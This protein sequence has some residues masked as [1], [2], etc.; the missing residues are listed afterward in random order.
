MNYLKQENKKINPLI[1]VFIFFANAIKTKTSLV[2]ILESF[3]FK[4]C[5]IFISQ[6]QDNS[7]VFDKDSWNSKQKIISENILLLKIIK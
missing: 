4:E 7:S 6:E 3:D 2:T 5:E 1:P